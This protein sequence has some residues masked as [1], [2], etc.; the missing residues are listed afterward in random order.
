M[1]DELETIWEVSGRGM[2]VALSLYLLGMSEEKDEKRQ[3]GYAVSWPR[4]EA[5]TSR[6]EVHSVSNMQERTKTDGK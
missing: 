2:F 1:A 5:K 4:F 3:T 6:I